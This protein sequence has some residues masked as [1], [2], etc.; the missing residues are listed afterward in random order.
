MSENKWC[1][2]VHCGEIFTEDQWRP[3]EDC[4]GQGCDGGPSD[5]CVEDWLD[6][7]QL[8]SAY[9]KTGCAPDT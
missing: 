3:G 2:C 6:N 5:R 1:V 7:A 8:V 9:F 4:P